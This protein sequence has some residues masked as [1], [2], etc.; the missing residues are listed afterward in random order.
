VACS[1]LSFSAVRP[2]LATAL[3]VAL[4]AIGASAWVLATEHS[5]RVR[6]ASVAPRPELKWPVSPGN[7][8]AIRHDALRR[9]QFQTEVANPTLDVATL[10]APLTCRFLAEAPTG[11]SAKFDCVLPSGEVVKVKYGRNPEVAAEVAATRLVEALGF[12]A[13]RMTI[14]PRVRC[15]GCPRFPFFAM[16]LLQFTGLRT[17]YPPHGSDEGYSDFEWVAIERKFPAAAIETIDVKGWAW[18]E[19]KHVDPRIG[20]PREDLDALRL[21]A[22]FLAHWDNKAENQRLVCLDEPAALDRPCLRPLAMM[23]DLGATFGPSKLNLHR[24]HDMPVWADRASCTVSM[25]HLPWGGAT[26]PDAQISEAGRAHLARRLMAITNDDVRALF[27]AAR[28]PEHYSATDD[29]KDLEAWTA[30]FRDRVE[31]IASATCPT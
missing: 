28:F 8:A 20:T 2:R 12:A 24:W 26:F 30:A 15:D 11:T 3:L 4:L 31:Q 29:A 5:E 18:W 14:A 16:R 25:R 22:V 27:Q 23:Q 1:L 13:D 7:A 19:L 9:A 10:E 21:L 6:A 17:R